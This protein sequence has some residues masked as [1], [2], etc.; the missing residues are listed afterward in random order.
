MADA[1]SLD[2]EGPSA[3]FHRLPESA[4]TDEEKSVR[5]I[6]LE[7]RAIFSSQF[8]WASGDPDFDQKPPDSTTVFEHWRMLVEDSILVM[9]DEQTEAVLSVT[10]W[11]C[12]GNKTIKLQHGDTT[13]AHVG[14]MERPAYT[15]Q[16]VQD[17]ELVTVITTEAC[18]RAAPDGVGTLEESSRKRVCSR[19]GAVVEERTARVV[20]RV[21]GVRETLRHFNTRYVAYCL[22]MAENYWKMLKGTTS[23]PR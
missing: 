19:K 21:M 4:R 22:C 23:R 5:D 15:T 16:R 2:V 12:R 10:S 8:R 14:A 7:E 11:C 18:S 1:V 20:Q 13:A 9:I 6:V 3:D 17:G